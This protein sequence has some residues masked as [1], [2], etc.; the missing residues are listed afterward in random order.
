[1]RRKNID[2]YIC[3]VAYAAKK[4]KNANQVCVLLGDDLLERPGAGR[5]KVQ[6]PSGRSWRDAAHVHVTVCATN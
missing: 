1:M 6:V 4:K 5:R 2:I 3:Y